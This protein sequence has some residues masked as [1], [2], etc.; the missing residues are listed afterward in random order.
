LA[1]EAHNEYLQIAAEIGLVGL[2]LYL[3]ILG[4]FFLY[5]IRGLRRRDEGFR[6]LVLMGCLAGVAGQAVD[7]LSNPAW[8]FADVSF[9]L[10]LM[11]G[12]GVAVA[13]ASR[14]PRKDDA[15]DA[16]P[17]PPA[18]GRLGWQAGAL[19]LT[20]LAMGGAWARRGVCAL[21]AY[22]SQVSV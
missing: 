15:T 10:W 19:G 14:R 22:K 6:K 2:G 13:R 20:V 8:R 18:R 4:A 11:M 17:V 5:G 3:W 7:A 1:E 16:V 12:L 21:P 9:L